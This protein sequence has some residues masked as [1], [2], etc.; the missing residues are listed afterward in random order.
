MTTT[1]KRFLTIMTALLTGMLAADAQTLSGVTVDSYTME[2][3]GSFLKVD[4]DINLSE[5]DVKGT[6][7]VVLTPHIINGDNSAALKSVG[8]YGRNRH[9]YYERNEELAPTSAQD[10]EL[11]SNKLPE[12]VNYSTVVPFEEWMDGCQLIVERADCGCNNTTMGKEANVVVARFPSEPCKPALLYIRPEAEKTKTR[13]LSGSAFIDFPVNKT[14]IRPSYRNNTAELSKITGTIDSVKADNDITITAISIKGFASPESS[15]ANNTRLAKNRTESLK[16]YVEKLY[17]FGE[18]VITTSYEPENWAGLESYVEASDLE[19]KAAIL[20]IIRTQEDPDRREWL[21]KSRYAADYKYLLEN[22]YP[23]LRRS[24][25]VI[26]YDI[27]QYS[28]PAE[29]ESVMNSAPQKLSLEEFYLLAETYESGSAELDALW[30]KAVEMYPDDEIA[31]FNAANSAIVKGDYE[32]AERYLDKAGNRAEVCYS[33]GCMEVLRGDYNA[34][35]PHL[36]EAKR[37]GVEGTDPI[38]EAISN[39]WIVTSKK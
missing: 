31:N 25:Y 35:L 37:R 18:G 14:D 4:M 2:R 20:D 15:Y 34:A 29:I 17:N 16:L 24:D 32:R 1:M 13:S 23:A 39:Y 3:S 26:E 38:I 21:I 7:V 36:E 12:V 27:R 11:R 30:E 28:Q 22:C 5:L 9:F 10:I 6:Q 19:N 33:R 8:V